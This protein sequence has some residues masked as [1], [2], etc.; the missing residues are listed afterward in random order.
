MNSSIAHLQKVVSGGQTG[1]DRGALDAA[2]TANVPHGGWCP[3]GRR[4]EDGSIPDE[5]ALTP[6]GSSDY[7][8]RTER[9][10]LDSEGTL[11]LCRGSLSGG[12]KLTRELA[13]SNERPVHVVDLEKVAG[14]PDAAAEKVI[15]WLWGHEISI[16]N[17]AG[18]R[19]SQQ[20]G[21]ASA[22]RDFLLGVFA[23]I[24]KFSDE[25]VG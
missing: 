13:E 5:Y 11:I 19:E 2:I 14:N 4:A 9:N 20:P 24:Q 6:T 17:V 22:A 21:I 10:V 18:P 8:V 23:R 16:L 15:R 12:T 7:T 1:V 3:R 25:S